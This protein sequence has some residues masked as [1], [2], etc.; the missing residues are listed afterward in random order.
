LARFSR[1]N[2]EISLIV[3]ERWSPQIVAKVAAGEADVGIIM[4]G[5]ET[6]DLEYFPYKKDQLAI[7]VPPNH[8][9]ANPTSS[10]QFSDVLDYDLIALESG[11]SMMQLLAEHA[12]AVEKGLKLRIQVRSFEVV[13]RMVHSGLGVGILPYQAAR[14]IGSSIQ[15]EIKP[16]TEAWATR[17]MLICV[18]RGRA[19]TRSLSRLI[20]ALRQDHDEARINQSADGR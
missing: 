13:C 2:P 20:S 1:E 17:Q 7:I 9:L 19:T 3:D 18:K 14:A 15:L 16:L 6:D 11:A 10:I 4:A 12:I 5:S 8:I